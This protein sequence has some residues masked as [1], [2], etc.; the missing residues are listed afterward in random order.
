MSRILV[1]YGTT[2]GQTAKIANA[3]GRSLRAQ[4][5]SV[6]V[7]A[8]GPGAPDSAGF[9][10]V[11]VAASVHGGRYQKPVERWVRTHAAQ[12]AGVPTAFVSVSLGVLQQ[13]AKVQQ[14]VA[15]IV[16]RF[17]LAAG[18]TPAMTRSVAGALVYTKYN[19]IK[20][21]VMRR[22]AKAAGGDTDTSKDYEYTDWRQ[23]DELAREFSRMVRERERPLQTPA[24]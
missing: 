19:W 16:R 10:G 12:L 1:L 22:I 23:V 20:R 8:A 4:G 7:V 18:W 13:E 24:A 11:L 9:A 3:I 6:E 5:D 2:E 14:E 15:A 21:R 17:L